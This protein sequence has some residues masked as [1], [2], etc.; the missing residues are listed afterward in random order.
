MSKA[1]RMRYD[2]GTILV[3]GLDKLP[4]CRW[5]GR[6][7]ALRAPAFRYPE[8]KELLPHAIDEVMDPPAHA[9]G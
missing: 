9:R 6:V 5:D 7:G 4:H 3:E 8:I 2:R 1:V